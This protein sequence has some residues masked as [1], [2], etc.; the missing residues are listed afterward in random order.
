MKVVLDT[1][2]LVSA[3]LRPGG[4]P[5]DVLNL[6]LNGEIIVC[7][8]DRIL[9]EYESVLRRNKFK[10]A[11]DNVKDLISYIENTGENTDT[12]PLAVDINDPDDRMFVEVLAASSARY[13]ITGNKKH[14]EILKDRRIV[15]PKEF[16]Q[17]YFKK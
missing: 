1:N 10:F 13:L 15:T 9:D 11:P 7:L 16:M 2:V 8:D 6:I 3:V 12:V 14:F 4:P 5:G 17:L